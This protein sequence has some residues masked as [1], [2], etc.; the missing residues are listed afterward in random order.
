LGRD[1]A[2]RVQI[3]MYTSRFN[4]FTGQPPTLP[5]FDPIPPRYE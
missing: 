5:S 1:H 2:L 4:P 3:F